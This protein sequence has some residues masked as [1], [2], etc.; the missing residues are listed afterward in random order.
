MR[1]HRAHG[2]IYRWIAM[3]LCCTLC[4]GSTPLH[5]LAK[6]TDIGT[7]TGQND[8]AV[9]PEEDAGDAEGSGQESD[10]DDAEG[11]GQE[12][13]AKDPN[14]SGNEEDSGADT[15]GDG[16]KDDSQQGGDDSDNSRN[17]DGSDQED[18]KDDTDSSEGAEDSGES[19]ET[20]T[21]VVSENDL[22]A[23]SGNDL[24]SVSEND[25]SDLD[26][27][28]QELIRSAQEAFYRLLA[29]KDLMALLYHTDSYAARSGATEASP[30]AATLE[31]GQTLYIK[32]V[33]ITEDDVW[34]QVQYWLNGVEGMGYV[35]SY[36][37]AYSDEDW[38]AWEEE[39]LR[40]I[41]EQGEEDYDIT[42]YGMA[43]YDMLP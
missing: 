42:A 30:A 26:T 41:L 15:N 32:G 5:A 17:P 6:E 28:R 39:Y 34:Y 16:N 31:I 19:G 18:V 22:S 3:I 23:V 14:D 8:T 40:P 10:T 29:E 2:V 13:G 1:M 9:L 4:L 33:T 36:Y 20:D 11:S 21:D 27:G 12:N 24:T 43:V 25:L 38:I 7:E 37:L 35:Q